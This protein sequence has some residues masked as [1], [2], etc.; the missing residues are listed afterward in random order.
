MKSLE[1]YNAGEYINMGDYKSFIPSKIDEDWSWND[2]ELNK[3]VSDANLQLGKLDG[4]AQQIPN[5]DLYIKMHVKVEAN[6]SS[7]I[8]GTRT[9]LDED[10]LSKDDIDPE[11]R[12]DWQEVQ[13]YVDAM[14]YGIERINE[15]PISTRLIKEIHSILMKNVRGKDKNPG[16]YRTSQNWIG[17]SRPGNAVYVPPIASEINNC[18]NDLEKFINNDKINTPDLVKIAMIHYQFESI[19][20]FLDGNGRTG[21]IIIPLYLLNKGIITTPCFY[22]SNYIEENKNAY[23]DFLSRVRTNNDM[24][25]WIK[26]FL[27]ATIETAKTA[28]V[29]FQNILQFTK[30]VDQ[31]LPTLSVKYENAKKIIDFLY[32]QPKA[33]RIEIIEKTKIPDSTVNGIINEL[34]RVNLINEI[35]GFSRNK[36]YQFTKYIE[37]F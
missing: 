2:S 34:M 12:D 4:Y 37:L 23:Y 16:E 18:L 9:T 19:H 31:I 20:P 21:R 28:R 22:I 26:F 30:E 6:K 14:N 7:R 33:S 27:E 5:V 11:K 15:I 35:T 1:S 29:K 24:I 25:S 17:G 13:N 10:L 3:L 36:V 8:E 32:I